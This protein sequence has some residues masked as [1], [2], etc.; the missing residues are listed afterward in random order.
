MNIT[1][2]YGQKHKGNTWAFTQSFLKHFE[3]DNAHV[4]EFFL[5][6]EQEQIGYCIGCLNCILRDEKTCPHAKPIQSIVSALDNADIIIIAS[7][8]Y[9]MNVT[10][11]LKTLFDHLAYRYMAHRPE[12]SMFRK[13][14]LALSTAAG[15]GMGKTV[16]V[17]ASNLFWWGIPQVERY[18]LRVF[19]ENYDNIPTK[20]KNA[21]ERRIKRIADKI[22]RNNNRVKVGFKTRFMFWIMRKEMSID[23]PWNIAD[24]KYWQEKGWLG[25]ERPY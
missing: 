3:E 1:I 21:I 19:A 10:G 15:A 12:A 9:V 18:G 8:C 23:T 25:K 20:R 24:R 7:P 4:T 5:P 22:K 14:G 17:I 11:Q 2:I 16:K 13:Q 6:N